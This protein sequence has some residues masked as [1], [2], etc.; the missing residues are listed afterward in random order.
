MINLNNLYIVVAHP[1]DEVI[2]GW[3][4]LKQAKKIITV[5]GSSKYDTYHPKWR[6]IVLEEMGKFLGIEVINLHY[7]DCFSILSQNEFQILFDKLKEVTKDSEIIFTHN[8]HGDYGHPDHKL[9]YQLVSKLNKRIL[10]SNITDFGKDKTNFTPIKISG[11]ELQVCKNDLD[12]YEKCYQIY[13]KNNCWTWG[14]PPIKEA[15]LIEK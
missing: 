14:H 15:I 12:F 10:V 5:V 1:D 4:V 8:E 7:E 6:D 11:K 2:F 13:L 3:L 9:L